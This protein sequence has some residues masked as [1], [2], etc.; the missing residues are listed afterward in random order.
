[1]FLIT[2]SAKSVSRECTCKFDL[3]PSVFTQSEDVPLYPA[4]RSAVHSALQCNAVSSPGTNA[5][6]AIER[7]TRSLGS[8]TER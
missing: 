4:G 2:N 8:Y 6:S 5:L 3:L 1:M 7:I